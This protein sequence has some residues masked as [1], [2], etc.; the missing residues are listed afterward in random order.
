MKWNILKF[1]SLFFLIITMV[2]CDSVTDSAASVDGGEWLIPQNQVFDGGPGRDGIPSLESPEMISLSD[3]NYL[4]A[5]DL[6]IGVKSG[7]VVRAYPHKILDW[8][9]IINDQVG[10]KKIAVTYCP[11]TGSAIGWNRVVNGG[12]TTFGVSGLLYNTNLIPYDRRTS[13]NWSQMLLKSV[14]GKNIGTE[15]QLYRVVETT[16][17]TW[18]E[19]YPQS[20]VVSTNTGFSRNYQNFPYGDYRTNNSNIIFPVN[21]EDNRLPKKERVLG[22]IVNGD[23]RA[24]R[25]NSFASGINAVNDNLGG[26]DIVIVGSKAKN[27]LSAY[28]RKSNDGKVL[29]FTALQS[30][31]IAVMEDN[32]GNK[33][34]FFGEVVSGERTGQILDKTNSYLAYW[35][36]WGA[37]YHNSTIYQ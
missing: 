22:V 20:K 27:F 32:E 6:V 18:K 23:S 9:E 24:Y 26:E 2:S 34:N 25:F 21:P 33:Y 31:S 3:A 29:R 30:D 5:D 37:F 28:K 4:F 13:S 1:V 12:E 7:S 35:F 16:W 8:H 14:N 17:A 10:D 36:A 15:I 19:M 11:L